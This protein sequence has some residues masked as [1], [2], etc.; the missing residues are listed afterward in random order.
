MTEDM[1]RSRM[2]VEPQ[3]WRLLQVSRPLSTGAA[4]TARQRGIAQMARYSY[5]ISRLR[6]AS[7]QCQRIICGS[8]SRFAM[9]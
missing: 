2:A 7:V 5:V 6:A 9:G 3:L 4:Q 1:P 8:L